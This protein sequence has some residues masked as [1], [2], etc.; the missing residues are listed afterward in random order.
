M[1]GDLDPERLASRQDH[2]F[3]GLLALITVAFGWILWPFYGSVLWAVVIGIL[4]APLNTWFLRRCRGRRTRAALLT[5]LVILVAVMLPLALVGVSLAQEAV[6]MVQKVQ[7]GEFNLAV[8]F[9]QILAAVPNWLSSQ[10]TRL[11]FGSLGELQK[12][13]VA[14]LTTGSQ[15]IASQALGL[16]Q[17]TFELVVNF[18]ITLYLAF[19]FLRDGGQIK[20]RIGHAV[21]LDPRHR[22]A[23]FEKFATVIRATVKG[24]VLVAASQGALGGLAFWFLDVHGALLWAVLMALLSLLPAVGAALVWL[25]VALYFLATGQPWEGFGLIAYGVLV[26]GLIDNLMRPMLV[27]KDIKLPDYLVLVS[28]LGGMAIF[29]LNGFVIGPVIAALFIA[30]WDLFASNR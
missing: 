7:S 22:G 1:N 27:G 21:P 30:S 8:Y 3:M 14:G 4:F 28:T 13:A 15:M 2:A 16:G 10:L 23:L 12:K 9:D 11:G 17:N 18:F 29:G 24:N 6:A 5:V 19:F 20:A 26:I 25:P